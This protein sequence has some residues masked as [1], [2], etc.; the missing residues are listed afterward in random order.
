ML[1]VILFL[2]LLCIPL[3]FLSN[4]SI[5]RVYVISCSLFFFF[6]LS[7]YLFQGLF[8]LCLIHHVSLLH[9][10]SHYR[11]P[12][13]VMMVIMMLLKMVKVMRKTVMIVLASVIDGDGEDG[14]YLSL[15]C[16]LFTFS[17]YLISSLLITPFITFPLFV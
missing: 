10:I 12:S 1:F 5:N 16:T 17:H 8:L 11:L 14:H 2:S 7:S 3:F 9:L 4:F 15:L 6:L 13:L